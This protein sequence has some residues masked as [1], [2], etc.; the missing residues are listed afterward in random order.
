MNSVVQ[1]MTKSDLILWRTKQLSERHSVLSV[2]GKI[3]DKTTGTLGQA[4]RRVSVRRSALVNWHGQILAV[5]NRMPGKSILQYELGRHMQ[6]TEGRDTAGR[7][8]AVHVCTRS[9]GSLA[10]CTMNVTTSN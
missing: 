7:L 2:S 3:N 1:A 8:G 6:R 9:S 10:R 4:P 5:S